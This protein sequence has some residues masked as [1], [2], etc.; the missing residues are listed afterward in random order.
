MDDSSRILIAKA[1]QTPKG[2]K[3]IHDAEYSVFS[4]WGDDGI[5]QYLISNITIRNSY[6]V[7]FGVENYRESNTRFLLMN[8]NWSGFVMDGS[9]Q[10]VQSIR[11]ADY[12]WKYDLEAKEYFVTSENIIGILEENCP[13]DIG[14]LHIDI[15]GMDYWIW[16]KIGQTIRPEIV[17]IEYNSVFGLDRAITIPYEATFNRIKKHYSGLYAGASLKAVVELS[18][19]FE[20]TFVGSNS[21]G[22]NAYFVNNNNLNDNIPR[23]TLEEGFVKSKFRESRNREGKLTFL[24]GDE[25]IKELRGLPVMNVENNQLETL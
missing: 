17:I 6:F 13:E 4:Q 25:R 10:N 7:E 15:D 12:Y 3:E 18:K 24:R 21:A 9:K 14:L 19:Q 23:P 1:I 20:Y 11:D 22:N 8:N 2:L 16:K 5:I